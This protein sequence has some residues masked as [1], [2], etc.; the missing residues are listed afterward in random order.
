VN[1][2]E[3]LIGCIDEVGYRNKCYSG[4]VYYKKG[5]RNIIIRNG[6]SFPFNGFGF[7]TSN[8]NSIIKFQA[9]SK[10]FDIV[11]FLCAIRIC[12]M[13]FKEVAALLQLLVNE[14]EEKLRIIRSK[15]VRKQDIKKA[16][17]EKEILEEKINSLNYT[18]NNLNNEEINNLIKEYEENGNIHELIDLTNM[19]SEID[20]EKLLQYEKKKQ[21]KKESEK[22]N[23]YDFVS[24]LTEAEWVGHF[25]NEKRIVIV[26]D[27]AKIHKA[28][29][30]KKV[31]KILNIKLVFLEKYS[32][33]LN[34]IER[35]WYSIKDKL[36]TK[37][38][39]NIDSLKELF[40]H[41]FYEYAT[42][43]TLTEK[44]LIEYIT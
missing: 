17:V 20:D 39:E 33:D 5:W 30:T 2:D 23:L 28:V 43:M 3:D 44:W 22:S 37:Y 4:K 29:L 6:E 31:A 35:V 19:K 36:S 16:D 24:K 18:I 9:T 27:N 8:G 25:K 38:I 11:T 40:G 41:Y 14:Y 7:Q 13:E 12:N 1:P 26:L 15:K 42:S 21:Q 32:S 34:P 10:T